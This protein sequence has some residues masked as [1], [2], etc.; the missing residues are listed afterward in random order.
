M[1]VYEASQGFA[2]CDGVDVRDCSWS[3]NQFWGSVTV[4]MVRT[5][6]ATH[7]LNRRPRTLREVVLWGQAKGNIDGYLREFLDEF[8]LEAEAALRQ[9]MLG[10]E[11]PLISEGHVD[12]YVAAVAEHLA[13]RYGLVIPEWTSRSE[14]FLRTPY[15]PCGL[16]SLKATLLMESPSAFRRRLIFVG[17]D[18]LSRPRREV[19]RSRAS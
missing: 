14:R 18:P 19:T 2:R 16:E 3:G 1:R 10:D 7:A 13:L 6:P 4:S 12:A 9:A 11:P 8:Y 15:F 17:I 5:M